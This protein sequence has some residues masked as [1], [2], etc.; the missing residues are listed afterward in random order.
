MRRGS[1]PLLNMLLPILSILGL[2]AS[3]Y[4]KVQTLDRE[5]VLSTATAVGL[6]LLWGVQ[7]WWRVRKI[8]WID[9]AL[10]ALVALF[11]LIIRISFDVG[12]LPG[13]VS[14]DEIWMIRWAARKA[15]SWWSIL[16]AVPQFA[17]IPMALTYSLFDRTLEN[18]RLTHCVL[19]AGTVWALYDLGRNLVNRRVALMSATLLAVS[20]PAIAYSRVGLHFLVTP[21]FAAILMACAVRAFNGGS[22]LSWVGAALAMGCG[23]MG[24]QSGQLLP[25]IFLV[26]VFP[27]CLF[28]HSTA[29]R[30]RRVIAAL[31]IVGVGIL[32]A[33]PS[34]LDPLRVGKMPGGQRTLFLIINS[35]R[36]RSLGEWYQMKGAEPLDI[37]LRH[38]V[39]GFSILWHGGDHLPDFGSPYP[40]LDPMV[41]VLVACLPLLFLRRAKIAW[42][43]LS[44]I[45]MYIT[46]G[47]VLCASGVSYHRILAIG[48]FTSLGAAAVCEYFVPRWL[49]SVVMVFV[50]LCS[51]GVNLQR[52]FIEYPTQ[53]APISPEIWVAKQFCSYGPTHAIVDASRPEGHLTS[54]TFEQLIQFNCGL[55]EYHIISKGSQLWRLAGSTKDKVLVV[56]RTELLAREGLRPPREYSVTRTWFDERLPSRSLM[57]VELSRNNETR[58]LI[59]PSK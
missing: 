58:T 47:I 54:T 44:W 22:F 40:F 55:T 42:L 2:C 23:V 36:L 45:I 18:A 17:N 14:R 41:G 39:S 10:A 5:A 48:L 13:R 33:M 21:F 8:N 43:C 15:D 26:S 19:G 29:E 57:F 59:P 7:D 50:C 12:T 11:A 32:I 52:Y 49:V 3:C 46:C 53:T 28:V 1:L 27:I 6:L 25:F 31:F 16:G 30:W 37:F 56:A 35:D 38:A 34:F 24:Y 9:L 20:F 51:A 4:F